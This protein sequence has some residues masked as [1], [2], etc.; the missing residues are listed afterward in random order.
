MPL[1]GKSLLVYKFS[2]L[3]VALSCL[4]SCERASESVPIVEPNG[5]VEQDWKELKITDGLA[6]SKESETPFDGVC[7]S[8]YVNGTTY[9]LANFEAGMLSNFKIWTNQGVLQVQGEFSNGKLSDPAKLFDPAI[10]SFGLPRGN[11]GEKTKGI[12]F[13]EHFGLSEDCH[14]HGT[15]NLW[16][17]NGEKFKEFVYQDGMLNGKFS[18]FDDKGRLLVKCHYSLGELEGAWTS[19]HW[20]QG[21]R[22]ESRSY[23]KG[24]LT[25]IWSKWGTNGA[26]KQKTFYSKGLKNGV[27]MLW[28][29]NGQLAEKAIYKNDKLDGLLQQYAQSGQMLLSCAYEHD[30]KVGLEKKWYL[31]GSQS[32]KIF[33]NKKGRKSGK[34][35]AWFNNGNRKTFRHYQNGR[36]LQAQSWKPD[37]ELSKEQVRDGNGTLIYYLEN[38]SSKITQVYRNGEVVGK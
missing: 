34:I 4:S 17:P 32:A 22:S 23:R 18:S 2:A 36:L 28:H 6:Y 19:Y 15:W 26:M 37:G 5:L 10:R 24:K 7:R 14:R 9:L 33:W 11:M 27:H 3:V 30:R 8:R 25:G 20:P 16:H 12:G 1:K 31:N 35:E 21:H 29:D 13:R 38:G